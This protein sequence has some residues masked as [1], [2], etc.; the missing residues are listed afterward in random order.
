VLDTVYKLVAFDGRPVRKLSSGKQT[1]PGAKQ[2]W[3]RA[4]WSADVL[5]LA[6]EPDPVPDAVPLLVE[7]MHGGTRTPAGR[8][9]LAD[10]HAR[11]EQQFVDLPQPLKRLGQAAQYEVVPTTALERMTEEVDRRLHRKREE[12]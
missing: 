12:G 1:W 6:E 2:V 5:G 3:R 9:T 4:G 7:V 10:A 8:A 11:F